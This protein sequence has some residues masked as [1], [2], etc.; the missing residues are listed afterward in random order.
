MK[1]SGTALVSATIFSGTDKAYNWATDTTVESGGTATVIDGLR[2]DLK[3]EQGS[4]STSWKTEFLIEGVKAPAGIDEA[5]RIEIGAEKW[6]IVN[7][8]R[9][10]T[11]A[12]IIFGLR[13]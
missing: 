10:P 6:N 5:A 3:Q 1:I 11:E 13:K 2:Y 7:V 12:I 8:N 4:G 9:V